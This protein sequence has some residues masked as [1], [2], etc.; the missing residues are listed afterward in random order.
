MSESDKDQFSAWYREQIESFQRVAPHYKELATTLQ[1][2]LTELADRYAPLAIVQTRPKSLSSFA[3]KII[4]KR[5]EVSDPVNEFTD[6]CGGRVITHTQTEVTSICNYIEQKSDD[7]KKEKVFDID[8]DNSVN[9]DQRLKATEFGYRSVHY[10]VS[11]HPGPLTVGSISIE[12]PETVARLKAEIQ[13]RTLLEHAWADFSHDKSYKSSFAFP[14]QWQRELARIAAV[15]EDAD[16]SFATIEN[17]LTAYAAN[18]SAYMSEPQIREEMRTLG[19]I[20]KHDPHNVQHAHRIGRLAMTLGDWDKAIETF[21]K[22]AEQGY[23]P[24]LKDL[25][26]ALCK[27]HGANPE[28]ARYIE[29]QGYIETSLAKVRDPDT[30]VSLADTWRES[31]EGKARELYRQAFELDPR[32]PYALINY[33]ELEITHRKTTSVVDVVRPLM[34]MAI[35]RCWEQITVGINIPWAYYALGV[36]HLLLDEHNESLIAYAKA[37]QMS[38]AE[39]PIATAY[40]SLVKLAPVQNALHGYTWARTLLLIGWAGRFDAAEARTYLEK[41]ATP[42]SRRIKAPVTI[43]T[44]GYDSPSE[45]YAMSYRE[46]MLEAFKDY[47]GTVISSGTNAGLSRVIGDV[48]ERYPELQAIGFVPSA[49]PQGSTLDARYC[50]IRRRDG[51]GFNPAEP[52]QYWVDAITSDISPT[53][54]KLLGIDGGSI[55]A[56]EYRL[57]LALRASVAVVVGSG[58]EAA[59]LVQDDEWRDSETL[60]QLPKDPLSAQEFIGSTEQTLPTP[61]QEHIAREIHDIYRNRLKMTQS[62]DP[63]LAEW[64]DL[65]AHLKNSSRAQADHIA[66]KLKAAG[67]G[68]R[69]ARGKAVARQFSPE[70]VEIMAELEHGR[71]NVERLL[72]GWK[73]GPIKDVANKIS[74]YIIPWSGL[75]EEMKEYDRDAAREIPHLLEQVGMEVVRLPAN[76]RKPSRR[77]SVTA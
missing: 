28:S 33:L 12:V 68:V 20:L 22:F 2:I 64:D 3:E 43:V 4:R 34:R 21:T 17:R 46:L 39:W 16:Q 54:I 38:T 61:V 76:K 13:V 72:D 25:G 62:E 42:N 15:L 67:Y 7:G 45:S 53:S 9:I 49:L 6:L 31:D 48:Q 71:W 55:A 24:L 29:G 47:T 27:L 70:E 59:R 23:P 26:V 75:P 10:I 5:A 32:D 41:L 8:W 30:L 69:K 44:G 14:R 35:R 52:L 60:I 37:I 65:V 40:H 19:M 56:I 51:E 63:S 50:E 36:L 1:T 18:Y 74:P 66:K 58:E 57:A 11:L 73:W 77:K